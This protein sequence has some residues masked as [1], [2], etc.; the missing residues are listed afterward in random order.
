MKL[1]GQIEK[2]MWEAGITVPNDGYL[3]STHLRVLHGFVN[4]KSFEGM[5][6]SNGSS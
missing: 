6:G 5:E 3:D 1:Y 2:R 4:G